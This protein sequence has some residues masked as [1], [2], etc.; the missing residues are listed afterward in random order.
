MVVYQNATTD[1]EDISS[2][3]IDVLYNLI[4][5]SSTDPKSFH[6]G[7]HVWMWCEAAGGVRYQHHG[8]VLYADAGQ[9]QILKIADFTAPDSGTFAIPD[10]IA[11]GSTV[12][13]HHRLPYW[14]GVRV[15]T[16]DNVSEWQKEE[17]TADSCADEDVVVVQRVKFLLSN[18]HLIPKY[19]LL[20]SNCETVAVWCKTGCFRTFQVAGLVDGGKRNSATLA[21]SSVLASSLMGPLALPAIAGAALSFSAL[22]LKE[23]S[24]ESM[25]KERT[26][27]LNDEFQRW[28]EG[29]KQVC[30]IL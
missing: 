23:N 28:Q 5:S 30:I 29:K 26:R 7:D 13:S 8:I 19:D 3:D 18:P 25:W 1:D 4:D 14:H 24:N 20:E 6:P 15:T 2:E 9:K 17:Y 21:A 16:Y 22:L 11:S 10:S 12:N 27:I